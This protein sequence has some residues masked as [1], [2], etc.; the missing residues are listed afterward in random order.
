MATGKKVKWDR[1]LIIVLA[2]I[3]SLCVLDNT[4]RLSKE[5]FNTVVH[6][7]WSTVVIK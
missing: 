4:W 6:H 2:V 7:N 1:V 3:G 5:V